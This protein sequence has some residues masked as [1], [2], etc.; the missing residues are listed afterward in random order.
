MAW[1]AEYVPRLTGALFDDAR[2]LVEAN[3]APA[4]AF[5]AAITLVAFVVGCGLPGGEST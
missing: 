3:P 1:L 2:Q 5:A 4:L